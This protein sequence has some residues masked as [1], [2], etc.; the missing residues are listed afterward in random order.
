MA[1]ESHQLKN[2]PQRTL[3]FALADD[4]LAS[5]PSAVFL[6]LQQVA[7]QTPGLLLLSLYAVMPR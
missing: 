3:G 4:L 5:K 6:I 1:S 7:G 2:R